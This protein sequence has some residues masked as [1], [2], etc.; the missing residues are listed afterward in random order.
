MRR[1]P[2]I[3]VATQFGP[4]ACGGGPAIIRQALKEYEPSGIGWWSCSQDVS[5][6]FGFRV[7]FEAGYRIPNKLYPYRRAVASKGLILENIWSPLARASLEKAVSRWQPDLLW[8]IPHMWSIL[9]IAS[10]LKRRQGALPYHVTMQ[11]YMDMEAN[12]PMLGRARGKR[13]STLANELYARASSRDAT[14]REM[15]EDLHGVTG[16]LGAQMLHLGLE[17]ED[18]NYISTRS[19]EATSDSIRVAYAG[20]IQVPE[21]FHSVMK[22]FDRIN[23]KSAKPRIT[24]DFFGAH[25]YADRTWFRHEWMRE[26]GNKHESDLRSELREC[27]IGFAPMALN[28]DARYNRFSFPTK[29]ISYLAA[30]LPVL[31]VGHPESSVVRMARE[32]DTGLCWQ[33]PDVEAM[34][35]PLAFWLSSKNLKSRYS[36]NILACARLYFDAAQMR[37]RLYDCFKN[38]SRI[39]P[40]DT[41]DSDLLGRAA[42]ATTPQ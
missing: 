26:H 21:V 31:S 9:P 20:T 25:S 40:S 1:L 2:R 34:E 18:F 32:C 39:F 8:V 30:G 23:A 12:V 17:N 22:V 33:S 41:A 14:S 10:Y 7:G 29:F 5:A 15:L 3:L 16:Q 11:D 38:S 13:L 35:Q 37:S 28:D 27:S 42:L 6:A 4:N 36:G 19:P 24:V